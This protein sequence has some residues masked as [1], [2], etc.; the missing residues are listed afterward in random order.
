MDST[1]VKRQRKAFF[2]VLFRGISFTVKW[3]IGQGCK[4]YISSFGVTIFDFFL[5]IMSFFSLNTAQNSLRI[6]KIMLANGG[7][8]S[9][10]QSFQTL[11]TF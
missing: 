8:N 7:D 2:R 1:E 4:K 5:K 9:A 10:I 3:K 6:S 11:R